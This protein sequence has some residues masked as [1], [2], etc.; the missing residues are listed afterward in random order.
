MPLHSEPD[1]V[2]TRKLG[3]RSEAPASRRRGRGIRRQSRTTGV[4]R[5]GNADRDA[6]RVEGGREGADRGEAEI[7]DRPGWRG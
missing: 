5:A 2:T 4:N 7:R 3:P 6:S 1:D